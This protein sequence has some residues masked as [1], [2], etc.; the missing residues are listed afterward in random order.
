MELKSKSHL[1]GQFARAGS[2]AN[3]I[4]TFIVEEANGEQT[5]IAE[6]DEDV[7]VPGLSFCVV[8]L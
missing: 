2:L 4:D 8:L 3:V 6:V 1:C 5:G 7:E